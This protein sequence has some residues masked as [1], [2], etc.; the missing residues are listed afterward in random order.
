MQ[1]TQG[2]SYSFQVL[3]FAQMQ[4]LPNPTQGTL[5]MCSDLN[6]AQ[7]V[8]VDGSWTADSPVQL[9][10]AGIP[11]VRTGSGTLGNNGAF[12]LSG[13][14]ALPA[15]YPGAFAYLP[16]G[17][18]FAG[19]VAQVVNGVSTGTSPAGWY[20]A[21]FSSTVAGTIYNNPYPNAASNLTGDPDESVPSIYGGVETVPLTKFS[22]TGPG[23]FTQTTGAIIAQNYTSILP[24]LI[25]EFG[26]LNYTLFAERTNNAD[27]AAVS[28]QMQQVGTSASPIQ[29]ALQSG[30]GIAFSYINRSILNLGGYKTNVNPPTTLQGP[31]SVV[32]TA[33][34]TKVD[35]SQ[36]QAFQVVLQALA[37]DY[38]VSSGVQLEAIFS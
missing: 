37:A 3:T 30:T 20:F 36:T 1:N 38:Y 11:F 8:F 2:T 17:A 10:N 35:F 9:M 15:I 14:N 6:Y 26:G 18:I 33:L 21:Q 16:S 27:A 13:T 23:A 7:F 4:A 12:S 28:A 31:G 32:Q 22:C 34:Y 24:N 25:G 5:I 29:I 19:T